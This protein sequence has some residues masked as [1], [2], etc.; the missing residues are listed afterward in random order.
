MW[1]GYKSKADTKNFLDD[2]TANGFQIID[3]HA[4]EHADEGTLVEFTNALNPKNIIPIH[5]FEKNQY[6]SVFTQ[7]VLVL[8]DNEVL[9]L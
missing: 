7:N 9:E 1:E 3:I 5:T 2:M 4:S 6:S 8:N